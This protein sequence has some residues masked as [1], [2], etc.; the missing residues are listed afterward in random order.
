MS[1]LFS[2]LFGKMGNKECPERDKCLDILNMVLDGEASEEQKRY[3]NLHIDACLPCLNDYN[4]EKAIKELLLT[5]CSKID[6]PNGLAEAIKSK[7]SEQVD[8]S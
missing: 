5:K 3:L 7:L 8:Q 6:V 4:L 2:K 1:S